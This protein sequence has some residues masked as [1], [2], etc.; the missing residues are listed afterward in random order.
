MGEAYRGVTSVFELMRLG[1]E[2]MRLGTPLSELMRLWVSHSELLR[3]AISHYELMRL[4]IPP[5]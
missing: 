2:W 5:F 1:S 3:L 4:G